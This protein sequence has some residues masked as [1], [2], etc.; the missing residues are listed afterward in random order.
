MKVAVAFI[1][2]ALSPLS[3]VLADEI[4]PDDMEDD[5]T[6]HAPSVPKPKQPR[7]LPVPGTESQQPENVQGQKEPP[8]YDA[9]LVVHL[10]GG[11][12]SVLAKKWTSSGGKCF[13][14]FL[15]VPYAQPPLGSLRFSPPE[16]ALPWE[17]VRFRRT[18]DLAPCAQM[19]FNMEVKGAE[20]CLY[21]NVYAPYK[22]KTVDNGTSSQREKYPVMVWIHGGGFFAGTGSPDLYGPERIMDEVLMTSTRTMKHG[23]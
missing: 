4:L 23:H 15:K 8:K 2:L 7:P 16:P 14:S 10:P 19:D 21:L 13:L 9:N 17:G 18:R 20:D 5:S 6:S 3:L 12:G 11:R 22:T 1:F